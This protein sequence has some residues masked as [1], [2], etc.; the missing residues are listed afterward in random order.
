[1]EKYCGNCEHLTLTEEQQELLRIEH[2]KNGT[3]LNR[4]DEFHNCKKYNQ[5]VM[6][7]SCLCILSSKIALVI[8]IISLPQIYIFVSL[9]DTFLYSLLT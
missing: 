7:F 5:R 3:Y 4:W 6:P 1:M 8:F 2:R 9:L